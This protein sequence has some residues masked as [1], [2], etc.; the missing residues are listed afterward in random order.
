MY[1]GLA[2]SAGC[3]SNFDAPL[4]QSGFGQIRRRSPSLEYRFLRCRTSPCHGS[5]GTP[6]GHP[7][8]EKRQC[9]K[10]QGYRV[11]NR[12]WIEKNNTSRE[13]ERHH[14]P[15]EAA[16]PP[17]VVHYPGG[18]HEGRTTII[19][20]TTFVND[21]A[22]ASTR[23]GLCQPPDHTILLFDIDTTSSYASTESCTKD[24]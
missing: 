8:Q 15:W 9:H 3:N 13:E 11:S 12:A 22:N 4:G 16:E 19:K 24:T 17:S 6:P 7:E 21:L 2:C 5:R 10:D 18:Y 20:H 1:V 23:N 14:N